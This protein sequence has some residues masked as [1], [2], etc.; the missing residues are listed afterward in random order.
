MA[1]FR[2]MGV[3]EVAYHQATV[4]GRG[5]DHPGQ[6]LDYYGSRGETPLRWG[7]AGAARLGLVGEVTPA[8]YEAAFGPGGLRDPLLGRRLVS[9]QRPGFELVV[10]AHKSVA[11]LG[12]VGGCE[13]MHSILDAETSA[14]MGWLD[15]WFQAQGGRRGRAQVR[16]ATSGL[17]YAVTRHA[18]SRAGD[19]SP[20][21]HVL[22]ANVVEMLDTKGGHKG[23][24][25]A[26][27]RD[28][29]EAATMVGRLHAAA[30][31]V[32]L[33][34]LIEP[35]PGPSG[36]LRH[37][38]IAEIPQA[39]CDLYSKRA[40][41]IDAYL[42]EAGHGSYRARGVA[43]RETRTVKRHTGADELLP[44]WQ[45][46]L[47][48]IG[49]SVDRLA[50]ALDRA[51]TTT[52]QLPLGLTGAEIDALAADVLAS[53]GGLMRRHKVFTRTRLIA[54]IAPRL[55]GHDPAQLD[56]VIDRVLAS[57][58]VVPLIGLAGGHEQAYT[59]AEVLATEAAIA[60]TIGRLADRPGPRR[61]PAE[62]D[63]AISAAEAQ[64]GRA[65][66]PGQVDAIR[67]ICSSGRAVDVVIGVAGAGKTTALNTASDVL[68]AAG[69]QVLGAS[70]SGQAA[71]TLNQEAGI[72]SATLA[73]L[74]WRLDHH[75]LT[76]DGDTVVVLDEAA[77]TA[78]ADL[79]RLTVGIERAGA[80]LVL[81]GDQRQLS[82]IGPGGAIDALLERHPEIVTVLDDNVRQRDPA[83]RA[84]LA[85][86]RDGSV[87]ASVAWY[88]RAG[89]TATALTRTEALAAM[90]EQW[91]DDITAGH[92]SALL[93]WRR[94]DVT[95]LNRLARARYD[96]LGHLHGEDLIGPGG[97]AYAAGD[98]VVTLAPNPSARLVT[99]QQLTITAVDPEHRSIV[100]R[101][102][103]GRQISLSAEA[104]D[105]GHLDHAYALTVHRA[106]GATYDRA[107]VYADGGGRELGYVAMSRARDRT[108]LH[109][110]ADD[111]PQAI[112]DL[113]TDWGHENRQRWITD[114]P[115]TIGA[116]H[117][118]PISDTAAHHERLRQ[119]RTELE[120]LA[121]PD[122]TGKL[123]DTRH[124]VRAL[125]QDLDDLRYGAGRWRGTQVGH[126]AREKV[127]A[128]RQHH[129]AAEFARYPDM[130]IRMR[131]RWRKTAREWNTAEIDA[132]RRYD[133][134]AAP[135]QHQLETT[136]SK[137]ERYLGYLEGRASDRAQ[138]LAQHPELE[139]RLAAIER[140][141][142]PT[143]TI[144]ERLQ[145]LEVEPPSHSR[146][147]GLEL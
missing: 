111:L 112:E 3:D 27:L 143:P 103:D 5:D 28:T 25:S 122:P 62:V 101:T 67:A 83:E 40:D 50:T 16:T 79:L 137:A 51:R 57:R 6:A 30:R 55:Y 81:V 35:D 1:W 109:T 37:W 86:L 64:L 145:A 43:A 126:A 75:Q 128:A 107:H 100:V 120:A 17:T 95:D 80:K 92:R 33:G 60:Q 144:Q 53:G 132:T 63:D 121:P 76:L 139:H 38:R 13:E 147:L 138:W 24:D 135:I 61:M 89:R 102:D 124:R 141:L 15:D 10:S 74:L 96:Q 87:P 34:F 104:I 131:H 108:T 29:V 46:E 52:P 22:V 36:N 146:G 105:R 69:Y 32:E 129:Q 134:L 70:T 2:R 136:L 45:A 72:P 77:M 91:A 7:G 23:L 125:R 116:Q 90:V 41:E 98:Q 18:T 118:Q 19:P 117:R 127:E 11:V 66:T 71:R 4:V 142:H 93:A 133:E 106:Q 48:E 56:P 31:A 114:T 130:S 59:T 82:A 94:Q 49:W 44:H 73:S 58:A 20:H 97:R 78:D 88:T 47:T 21:D 99:S 65:F 115:A 12:V 8:G 110:V 84:A 26:A 123:Y 42:A 119:E 68:E 140:E 14:T 113:H 39:V 85:E 9:T 54:E